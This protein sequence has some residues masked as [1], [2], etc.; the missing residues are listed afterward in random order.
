MLADGKLYV[1]TESGK[2][3]IVRPLADRAEV[4]SE[5]E[6]PLSKDDNAGQSAGIAEPI[7]AGAAISRGR[8]FFVSTGGVYAIG[9]KTR[10]ADRPGSR[11]TSRS[12]RAKARRRGAGRRRP[13]WC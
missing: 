13:S 1:G 8:V 9:P 4:L 12:S 6:L 7:F 3:F 10:E 2:F 5:V 11:S